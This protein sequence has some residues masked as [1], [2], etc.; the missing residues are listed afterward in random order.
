MLINIWLIQ[1]DRLNSIKPKQTTIVDKQ[2]GMISNIFGYNYHHIDMH[3]PEL[4]KYW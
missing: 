2:H 1:D 3:T 4:H